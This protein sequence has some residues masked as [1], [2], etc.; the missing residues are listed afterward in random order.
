[1]N[2][3]LAS[4]MLNDYY[5]IKRDV[6][7]SRESIVQKLRKLFRWAEHTIN[8]REYKEGFEQQ[9]FEA[10]A[11][12][13]SIKD[14]T[15]IETDYETIYKITIDNVM[16]GRPHYLISHIDFKDVCK[17]QA[18]QTYIEALSKFAVS[19]KVVIF[20]IHAD[21][22]RCVYCDDNKSDIV[23]KIYDLQHK[24][25]YTVANIALHVIEEHGMWTMDGKSPVD[26]SELAMIP[27][28]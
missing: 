21:L 15:I 22:T 4:Q 24:R 13:K 11:Y 17:E 19:D 7:I 10:S 9:I 6:E 14:D 20:A 27:F 16:D 3:N 26:A 28:F 8:Q 25:G 18:K 5:E 12:W 1:M 2:H 23:Y